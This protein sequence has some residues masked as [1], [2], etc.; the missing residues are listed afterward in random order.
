MSNKRKKRTPKLEPKPDAGK[1]RRQ[2]GSKH[3]LPN[4]AHIVRDYATLKTLAANFAAGHVKAV[5]ILGAPGK[6]KGQIVRRAMQATAP[7]SDDQF[8]KALSV[9]LANI[10]ARLAPN[11][12][13]APEPPNL[14]PPLYIKGSVSPIN[15]HIDCYQHRDAPITID[16][17]DDF[18]GDAR[19][20]EG[21]KHLA[22]TD[23]FKLKV[24]RTLS[25]EL[26]AAGVPKEFWTTSPVAII[27]N[28]WDS[29]DHICQAILS[30]GI[31]IS[32]E[33]SWAEA[34]AYIAEWFWDQEIFD[35]LW[36]R[37]PFLKEPDLRLVVKAYDLKVSPMQI[38][39]LP[40]QSVIDNHAADPAHIMV[41]EYLG[42]E[43][44]IEN[45]RIAAWIAAVKGKDPDGSASKA[46]WH[47]ILLQVKNALIA[48]PRPPRIVLARNAPP[49]ETRPPDSPIG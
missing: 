3:D 10:L 26:V 6:G 28:V 35:Y 33:P 22:E 31:V 27:R 37:M 20:R 4:S 46:T 42:K 11:A 17:A 41:A 47:R 7:T 49:E 40:W 9:S 18:F 25:N 30:R 38:P 21:A 5:L 2:R 34:Y 29:D 14:G 36:E 24:H 43:F 12:S 8:M 32:F 13:P 15:F 16:D 19:L 23:K 44:A 39:G 45:E 1:A 48:A